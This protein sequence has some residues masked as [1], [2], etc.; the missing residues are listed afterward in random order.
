M[1]EPNQVMAEQLLLCLDNLSTHF[2][3]LISRTAYY[4]H[5]VCLE[6]ITNVRVHH[7][8]D[9]HVKLGLFC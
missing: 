3:I 6:Q 8:N 5:S 4:K 2:L 1:A 9:N 7:E